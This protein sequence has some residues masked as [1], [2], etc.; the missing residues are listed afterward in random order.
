MA[1]RLSDGGV[2]VICYTPQEAPISGYEGDLFYI[3]IST[4][5]H[6]AHDYAI[7]LRN[8]LLT[9]TDY[10]R[11]SIPDAGAVLTVKNLHDGRCE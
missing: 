8:S 4:P 2:R 7:N 5:E 3:T 11:V 9:N 1:D 10:Q 6:A